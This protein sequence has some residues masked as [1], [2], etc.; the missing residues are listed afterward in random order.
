MICIAKVVGCV[1]IVTASTAGHCKLNSSRIINNE[2]DEFNKKISS[3]GLIV[4]SN[5]YTVSDN[6]YNNY[7]DEVQIIGI[8]SLT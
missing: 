3:L 2:E 1:G 7:D 5:Q 8:L 6:N 4:D